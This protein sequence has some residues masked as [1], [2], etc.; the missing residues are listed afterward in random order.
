MAKHTLRRITSIQEWLEMGKQ[1]RTGLVNKR[2]A[3]LAQAAEID[4]DLTRLP[5]DDV[6]EHK[7]GV[8]NG[9]KL[10]LTTTILKTIQDYPGAQASKIKEEL[11]AMGF[12]PD[13]GVGS[14]LNRLLSSGAITRTGRQMKFHYYLA[15]TKKSPKPSTRKLG[16]NGLIMKVLR[17]DK[18]GGLSPTQMATSI[19]A[20]IGHRPGL[21]GI[22]KSLLRL[23]SHRLVKRRGQARAVR[24]SLR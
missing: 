10:G 19:D 22:Q 15:G 13:S 16:L 5:G 6:V 18:N 23:Q 17:K 24:Y 8:S 7:N 21:S 2:N 4:K 12:D 14:T 1:V 3:L 11:L 20:L 9:V